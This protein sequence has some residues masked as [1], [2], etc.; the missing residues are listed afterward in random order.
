MPQ[1]TARA[2][3]AACPKGCHE[4]LEQSAA[5]IVGAED[6]DGDFGNFYL[7]PTNSTFD[8]RYFGGRVRTRK[9]VRSSTGKSI[10]VAGSRAH[11]E[12]GANASEHEDKSS[13]KYKAATER[14]EA[15]R[16]AS[17]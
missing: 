14:Q 10:E 17:Q 1:P 5:R 4:P 12:G 6:A 13:G 3:G 7:R 15:E 9:N 11:G 2:Y 16:M 8:P